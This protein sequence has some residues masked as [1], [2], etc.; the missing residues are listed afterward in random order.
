[1]L[2]PFLTDFT[3]LWQFYFTSYKNF[4]CLKA[5]TVLIRLNQYTFSW[6]AIITIIFILDELKFIK[7]SSV[8]ET[9]LW[10]ECGNK[11]IVAMEKEV[12]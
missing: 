12:E 2:C 8:R 7:K 5:V 6:V 11:R 4:Q 1:M 9:V 3:V 10:I